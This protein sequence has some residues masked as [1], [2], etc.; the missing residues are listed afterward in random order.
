M[1]IGAVLSRIVLVRLVL[2]RLHSD[3]SLAVIMCI[4][5]DGFSGNRMSIA[6]LFN[7]SILKFVVQATAPNSDIVG[8][9]DEFNQ[10]F[11]IFKGL[12]FAIESRTP[13]IPFSSLSVL[14]KR[15]ALC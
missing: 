6:L 15:L 8:L 3:R 1:H 5:F 10:K 13:R 14:R 9:L 4:W 11:K 2:Q 12:I 7:R